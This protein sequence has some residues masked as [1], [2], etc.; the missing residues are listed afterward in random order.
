MKIKQVLVKTLVGFLNFFSKIG[1][2]FG[3]FGRPVYRGFTF[4]RGGVFKLF[5]FPVYRLSYIVKYKTLNLYAPARSKVFFILNKGYTVHILVFLLVFVVLV[6]NLSAKEIRQDNYGENT[7]IYALITK[8]LYEEPMVEVRVVGTPHDKILSYLD[9]T[10]VVGNQ[11][12]LLS[13]QETEMTD[14]L[15]TELSTV[16]QGGV[17]MVKPN[18][19]RPITPDQVPGSQLPDKRGDVVVHKVVAGDTFSSVAKKYNI[20]VNTLLW[21]NN[22]TANSVLRLGMELKIL[23][24]VGVSHKVVRGES[25]SVIA[26]KYKISTDQ[27]LAANNL[28]DTT[29]IKIGQ[30]LIVPGGKKIGPVV[31]PTVVVK[32]TTTAPL[33][34]LFEPAP[35]TTRSNVTGWAWPL[36]ARTITQ[37]YKLNHRGL[38]IAGALGIAVYAV[39]DGV[40]EYAGWSSGYGYNILIN[41][42]GGIKTRYAHANK[43]YVSKGDSVVKGQTIMGQGSTGW[44]TGPHL[45]FEVIVNGVKVNPLS[46]IR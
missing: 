7:V 10:M 26:N 11:Q 21:E 41:H 19:I 22:L 15:M 33:G 43:L 13:E 20:D 6:N 37:Y 17:A 34:T 29:D 23:P 5:V 27:I 9:K 32:K 38:D 31:K 30:V 35:T 18:I 39:D 4:L 1:G 40:V 14:A 46:Y 44:S 3:K 12:Q 42:G 28:L 25:V 36:A 16:T 2:L 45:H 24:M 8:E